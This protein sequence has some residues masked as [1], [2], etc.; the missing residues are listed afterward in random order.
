MPQR[1][2]EI[3]DETHGRLKVLAAQEGTTLGVTIERLLDL[4]DLQVAQDFQAQLDWQQIQE[5]IR[6][7]E[8]AKARYERLYGEE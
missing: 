1:N 8:A 5:S 6:I 4:H 3:S 2:F 7:I